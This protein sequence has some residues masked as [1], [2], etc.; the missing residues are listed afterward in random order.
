MSE[1]LETEPTRPAQADR[2]LP[3]WALKAMHPQERMALPRE[4]SDPGRRKPLF[5]DETSLD[6]AKPSRYHPSGCFGDGEAW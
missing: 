3:S 5:G 2:H 4:R 6:S 1:Q